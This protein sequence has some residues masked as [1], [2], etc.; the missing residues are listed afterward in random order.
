MK[1]I[2]MVAVAVLAVLAIVPNVAAQDTKWKLF[3]AASYVS[4]LSDTS[5]GEDVIEAATATG[6]EIGAEW[7]LGKLLGLELD[8]LQSTNDIEINGVAVTEVDINPVNLSAN[9]HL[10][11]G[12]TIDF[13][14]GAT[15][16]YVGYD[17]EDVDLDSEATFGAVAGLDIGLGKSFAITTGLRWLDMSAEDDSGDEL[18]ID[19]IFL[20]AG[21]A[22]RF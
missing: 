4:P 13:W 6:W 9:F 7:R 3:V 15:A 1:R 14:V 12:Q 19:P 11:P 10:I 2:A 20:R 22:F 17:A 16:A 5:D 21:V 18:S 8:Y